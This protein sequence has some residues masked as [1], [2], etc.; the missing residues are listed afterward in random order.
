MVN[1]VCAAV[2]RGLDEAPRVVLAVSGGRDSTVLLDAAAATLPRERLVVAT[3]DHGTGDAARNAVGAVESHAARLGVPVRTAR[4][5]LA[6][7]TEAAWREARWRFL[8]D[9]AAA[10]GGA[11]ATAHTR[12]DNLETIVLRVVRGAG[13]RGI[14][15]LFAPGEA[16]RPLVETSRETIAA[17]AAARRLTW[18]EDPANDSA[19]YL[20]NRIRRDLLPALTRARPELTEELLELGRRAA[21]WRVA[22]ERVVDGEIVPTVHGRRGL[23]VAAV[24]LAGYSPESLAV[25]WPAIAG[26]VGV[27]LDR[28]GTRRLVEFTSLGRAGTCVQLAGGWE[29]YRTTDRFELRRRRTAPEGAQTLGGPL[30][31]GEWRFTPVD[32][33]AGDDPWTASFPATVP[34][35]VREWR[36]GDSMELAPGRRRKV[37]QLLSDRHIAGHRRASWPVVLA[38][39]RIAWIPGVRRSDAATDRSGRPGRTYRCELHDR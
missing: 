26:R 24:S 7:A 23:D 38:G 3:F 35:T 39:E 36:P 28:R 10:E 16:L 34:L 18:V 30:E 19:A 22:V 33:P 17:Y 4:A 15:A 25:L 5:S 37:K 12:D 31:W 27:A 32:R 9:V 20:R 11:V 1:E 21:E 29:V 2:R 13:A 8:R 14:A 6:G